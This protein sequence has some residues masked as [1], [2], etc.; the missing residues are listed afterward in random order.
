MTRFVSGRMAPVLALS[1]VAFAAGATPAPVG[2]GEE[3]SVYL[4]VVDAVEMT[5]AEAVEALE[6]ALPD[7]GWEVLARVPTGG[8]PG[9]CEASGETLVIRKPA[10]A[11]A[12]LRHGN[13]AAFAI[14]LRVSVFE[15]DLG[16][17]VGVMD[18]RSMLRTMVAEEGFDHDWSTIHGDL[19][20]VMERAFPGAVNPTGYGQWRD[21]G[22]I[23]KT[24]GIMAGG[25]FPEKIETILALPAAT[26]TPAEVATRL[27]DGLAAPGGSEWGIRSVFALEVNPDLALVGVTGDAMEVKAYQIVG[28]GNQKEREDVRC[29]GV[30]HAPAFPIN[31]LVERDGTGIRIRLVDEMFRMKMYF[32]DAGTMAFARNMGMPGSIEDEI[33]EKVEAVLGG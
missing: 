22:R 3:Y 13:H 23:G 2:D 25:P 4:R 24:F 31:L 6:D 20:G 1:T 9:E 32:E 10:Y 8:I 11:P 26:E 21:E 33:R 27:L 29:A 14:P 15:D 18:P 30:D 5:T 17:H 28:A 12:L 7:A 19:M 16:V